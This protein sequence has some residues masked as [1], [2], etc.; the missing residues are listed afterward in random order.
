MY[1]NGVKYTQNKKNFHVVLLYGWYL[2][3]KICKKKLHKILYR[4]IRRDEKIV[5]GLRFYIYLFAFTYLYF[6]FIPIYRGIPIPI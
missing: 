1:E 3:K 4:N 5:N 6:I 2:K